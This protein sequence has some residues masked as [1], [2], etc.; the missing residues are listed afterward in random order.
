MS[1]VKRMVLIFCFDLFLIRHFSKGVEGTCI[2]SG[3]CE[4]QPSAGSP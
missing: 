3:K 1:Y 2:A 4:F